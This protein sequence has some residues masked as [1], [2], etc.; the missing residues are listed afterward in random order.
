MCQFL[1][2]VCII[3]NKI[4][5]KTSKQKLIQKLVVV[6]EILTKE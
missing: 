4:K 1:I 6:Q 2:L 5:N 3:S